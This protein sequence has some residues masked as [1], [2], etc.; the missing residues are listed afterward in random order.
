MADSQYTIQITAQ[1][2]QF[3][4]EVA[5]T[6]QATQ[7]NAD[8][9]KTSLSSLETKF[10]SFGRG[11]ATAVGVPLGVAG[12]LSALDSIKDKTL[13]SARALQQFDAVLKSTGQSAG[14]TR[15]ALD[16]ISKGLQTRTVF[17]EDDI[18][19]AET[20][21]LQFRGVQKDVFSEAL[22]L[23]ADLATRLGLDL[24]EAATILGKALEHPE[25]QLKALKAA[26]LDLSQQNIDLAARF[27]EAGDK[28]SAQRITLDALAQSIGGAAAA[29]NT[30]L[31]GSAGRLTRAWDD[32]QKSFGK[33]LF[34]DTTQVDKVTSALDNLTDRLK[35]TKLGFLDLAATIVSAFT[36]PLAVLNLLNNNQ[37][38]RTSKGKIT[39]LPDPDEAKAAQGKIA[40]DAQA[41]QEA[42]YVADQAA[43]KKRADGA[44][45]FYGAQLAKQK[46]YLD[47]ASSALDFAHQIDEV[48]DSAFY[49]RQRDLAQRS[50]QIQLASIRGQQEAQE[51]LAK[52]PS[53]N[54]DVRA[55]AEE[56]LIALTA[57]GEAAIADRDK[58]LQAINQRQALGVRALTDE[59]AALNVQL[60]EIQGSTVEAANAAFDL[61]HKQVRERLAAQATSPDPAERAAAAAASVQVDALARLTDAQARL[62]VV[63]TDFA[64]I[65]ARVGISQQRIAIE[66]SSG[67][68]TELEGLNKLSAANAARIPQLQAEEQAFR[69][70]AAEFGNTEKGKAFLLQAD[71]MKAK[72]EELTASTNLLADKFRDVFVT[73]TT[74]LFTDLISGTKT[75]KQSFLDYAKTIE[76][77]ISQIAAKN[78][79]ESLFGKE[80]A[81]GGI[82]NFF[83]GLFGGGGTAAGGAGG[84][85]TLG[86]ASTT[87]ALSLTTTLVPA[88]E[89]AA[90]A[91][92][93]ISPAGAAGS[94]LPDVFK[95]FDFGEFAAGGNPPTGKWSLVGEHGPELIR[96]RSDMNIVPN[97]VLMSKRSE[98]QGDIYITQH[99][100]PGASRASVE[101]SA[102]ATA[103]EIQRARRVS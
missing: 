76:Q 98:R 62:N 80:G 64:D 77:S 27:L 74:S 83:A 45:A 9:I 41:A 58:N 19:K 2:A 31:V 99:V 20:A 84:V 69:D 22:D 12:V 52:A 21:L 56:K 43:L 93:T 14:L 101:Q 49:D 44:S 11:L 53:S 65:I 100:A 17:N 10:V 70:L 29:S 55:G 40:A 67:Q 71:E 94:A 78:I 82:P 73:G 24:P 42:Q 72:I 61:S 26:G 5:R 54:S 8:K 1:T 30:G 95:L 103:R 97:D 81:L 87:T 33:K 68:I 79:S 50:L 25:T 16:D 13:E 91:L 15:G 96:P 32:L 59:Y 57:Q 39:G 34:A 28:A 85:A 6:A 90:L 37:G 3:V 75:A 60:I 89:T 46:V 35:T 4:A 102:A 51:A 66:V 36:N 47:A 7:A 86:T 18:R 23:T 88:I 38:S 92:A 63:S 48:S